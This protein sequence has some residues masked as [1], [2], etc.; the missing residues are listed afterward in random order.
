[1]RRTDY[2]VMRKWSMLKAMGHVRIQNS[3][4]HALTH[5]SET[6]RANIQFWVMSGHTVRSAMH[7]ILPHVFRTEDSCFGDIM[8]IVELKGNPWSRNSRRSARM[9]F[10]FK[11]NMPRVS[12]LPKLP[13][14]D[15]FCR[16]AEMLEEKGGSTST[17]AKPLIRESKK[18]HARYPKHQADPEKKSALSHCAQSNMLPK[19]ERRP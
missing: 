18:H 14:E 4:H 5:V 16:K 17:E 9:Q 15:F 8:A 6:H 10:F 19:D 3:S 2:Y 7:V 12:T 13:I 11:H 1:M